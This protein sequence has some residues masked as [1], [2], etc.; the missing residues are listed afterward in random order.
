MR[1]SWTEVEFTGS[2]SGPLSIRRGDPSRTRKRGSED[3]PMVSELELDC[4]EANLTGSGSGDL[5]KRKLPGSI[6]RKRGSEVC[7]SYRRAETPADASG[8]YWVR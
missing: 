2:N 6:T 1:S 4:M 8:S 5:S 7:A 3:Y